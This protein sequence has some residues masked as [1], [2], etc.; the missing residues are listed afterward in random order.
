MLG[1]VHMLVAL[2]ANTCPARLEASCLETHVAWMHWQSALK[3][4]T[5]SSLLSLVTHQ[6]CLI[7]VACVGSA[8]D[9]AAQMQ[10]AASTQL[11]A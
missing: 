4:A 2:T 8:G 1:H 9:K 7:A 3:A 5:V 10:A 11:P 6:L